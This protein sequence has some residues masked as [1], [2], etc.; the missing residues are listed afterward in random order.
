MEK[1]NILS[2]LR[3][4]NTVF[5]FR[6]ILLASG[7]TTTNLLKRRLNYYV[8]KGELYSI[9]RGFYAK[10]KNYDKLELA[11]KIYTPAYVSFETVL[12]QAGMIFQ[13]YERIFVAS[14]LTREISVDNQLYQYKKIKNTILTNSAGIETKDNYSI[15][16]PERAFLDILYL[17]K[18]YYF[19]NLGPLNWDKVFELLLI[20]G[21]KRME[22]VV[23]QI[24][25]YYN[26]TK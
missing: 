9:R 26:K 24:F 1:A 10:D 3:A 16:S 15:A 25:D 21:N 22:K 6:E 13:Y 5:S 14:Y 20:Y 19:D 12:R 11:T 17:N 7:E 8:K 18:N 23:K 2:I 4:S